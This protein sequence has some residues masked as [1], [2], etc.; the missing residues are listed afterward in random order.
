[1]IRQKKRRKGYSVAIFNSRLPLALIAAFFMVVL[2]IRHCLFL[3]LSKTNRQGFGVML[4]AA[5]AAKRAW[6]KS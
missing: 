2:L 1:M 4:N 5:Y 6:V 3:F